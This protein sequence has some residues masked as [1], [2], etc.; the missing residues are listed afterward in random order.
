MAGSCVG[1]RGSASRAEYGGSLL[2]ALLNGGL[3]TGAQ[4]WQLTVDLPGCVYSTPLL[5]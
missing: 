4:S 5:T 1:M 3:V 2:Q